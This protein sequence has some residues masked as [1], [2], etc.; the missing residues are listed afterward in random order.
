MASWLL[1]TLLIGSGLGHRP[2][3]TVDLIEL[4]HKY[5]VMNGVVQLG[6]IQV[7][8]WEW[9]PAERRHHTVGWSIVRPERLDDYPQTRGDWTKVKIERPPHRPVIVQSRMFRETHTLY[10]PELVDRKIREVEVH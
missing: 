5:I 9:S 8:L 1:V 6:F 7:I 3:V 2:P 4:N 10:D